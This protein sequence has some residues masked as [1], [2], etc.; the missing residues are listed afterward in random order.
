VARLAPMAIVSAASVAPLGG[1]CSPAHN[2]AQTRCAE[3]QR[4]GQAAVSEQQRLAEARRQLAGVAALRNA[5]ARVRD[6]RQLDAAKADARASYRAA[7]VRARD[8]SEIH[9]A[10]RVWLHE[11]DR[12]NRLVALADERAD[13]IV[14]QTNE[15]EQ[16]LP[17]IEL[18][19]DA[20]RIAA[21]A[22][23]RTCLDA[24]RGLAACEEEARRRI[25]SV[26][27]A[28]PPIATGAPDGAARAT[29]ARGVR[30][31]TLVLHGDR[32][33]FLALVLRLAEE[34]GDEA[35]R[36]QLLLL[37]LREAIAAR[38]LEEHAVRFAPN[39]P[40][41][42]Q[43]S[44]DDA[45]RVVASLASL[46][47]RFDGNSGWVDG[48]PPPMRELVIA[49][50]NVGL[51]PRVVRRPMSQEGI[52]SLWR[53]TSV[54]VEEYLAARA[55]DLDLQQVT[56]CLGPRAAPLSELWNMW[57]RLRVLLLTPA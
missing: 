48:R 8:R 19:A 49:L 27:D 52:D 47:Y 51:D 42:S 46:G 33:T 41:W 43:F 2:E 22:A 44:A 16:S 39:Q 11:I 32:R 29:V 9:E 10:A 17:G 30:P 26:V 14:R 7:I 34:T 15:L 38:A 4:L 45:R 31:I 13:D 18:A 28:G 6:R 5:D 54:L 3:A 1:P 20:A 57:G 25:E 40:F 50:S 35:G 56:A 21:E 23:Q 24:R 55:P 37:E 12:L 53:G 36:L